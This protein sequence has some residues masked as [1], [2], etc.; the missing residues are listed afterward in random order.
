M[1]SVE[2]YENKKEKRRQRITIKRTERDEKL[3]CRVNLEREKCKS[4]RR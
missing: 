4:E 2:D 3:A 1:E